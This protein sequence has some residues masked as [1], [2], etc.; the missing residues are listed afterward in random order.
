VQKGV[1]KIKFNSLFQQ[2][3][4]AVSKSSLSDW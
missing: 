4:V 1:E 2:P 3:A